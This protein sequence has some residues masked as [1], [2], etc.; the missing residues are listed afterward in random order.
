M[1]ENRK[2]Y[3][4]LLDLDQTLIYSI[5]TEEFNFDRDQ[6]KLEKLSFY[7]MEGLYIVVERPYVQEFLDYIFQHFNV[8]VWTAATKDY[9]SSIIKNVILTKPERKLDF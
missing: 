7:S 5:P 2:K 1:K 8:S 6:G 4:L 3:N 9:A